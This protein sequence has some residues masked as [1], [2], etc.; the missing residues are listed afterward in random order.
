MAQ[1][2]SILLPRRNLNYRNINGFHF[3][4]LF[5]KRI[6]NRFDE[7]FSKKGDG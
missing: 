7:M 5:F 3:P 4:S 6:I 2:F 1:T